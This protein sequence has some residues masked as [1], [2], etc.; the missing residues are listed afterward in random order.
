L[1]HAQINCPKFEPMCGQEARR[2][3]P[4][5]LSPIPLIDLDIIL[6]QGTSRVH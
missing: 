6:Y 2:A 3:D 1:R 5:G 4:T